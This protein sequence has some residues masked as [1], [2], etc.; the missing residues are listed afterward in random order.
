MTLTDETATGVRHGMLRGKATEVAAGLLSTGGLA[1]GITATAFDADVFH[2]LL[3]TAL[4]PLPGLAFI[5]MRWSQQRHERRMEREC[6]EQFHAITAKALENPRDEG[7]RSLMRD[8]RDNYP[9]QR[10][11]SGPRPT[12]I[13]DPGDARKPPGHPMDAAPTLTSVGRPA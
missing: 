10:E 6:N 13:D 9:S 1:G 5:A 11:R 4:P 3:V 2:L 7:L 8:Y 12:G